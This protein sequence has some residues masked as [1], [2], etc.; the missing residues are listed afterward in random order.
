MYSY[1]HM[2]QR[3]LLCHAILRVSLR[4]LQ[5]EQLVWQTLTSSPRSSCRSCR[6]PHSLRL[7]ARPH[8]QS[9]VAWPRSLAITASQQLPWRVNL[10]R[11]SSRNRHASWQPA[12][13][14]VKP[15]GAGPGSPQAPCHQL[16]MLCLSRPAGTHSKH[17]MAA[18]Y[19][20]QPC[21]VDDSQAA[22]Q[23]QRIQVMQGHKVGAH[24]DN[25]G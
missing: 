25:P 24:G 18:Q 20:Q 13:L 17:V 8:S 4:L 2:Q 9:P 15:A 14:L 22:G 16:L 3:V 1:M 21:Q 10:S 7:A 19:Q 6:P 11:S 23:P 5:L 12:V